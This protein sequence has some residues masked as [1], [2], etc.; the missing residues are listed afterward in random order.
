MR[1]VIF[2]SV[3]FSIIQSGIRATIF[4]LIFVFISFYKIMR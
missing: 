1:F 2:K 4:N 3:P